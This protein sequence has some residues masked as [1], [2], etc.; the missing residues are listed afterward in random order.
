M[1]FFLFSVFPS[2]PQIEDAISWA[3]DASRL[4]SGHMAQARQ[5]EVSKETVV[6]SPTS[7]N[8]SSRLSKGDDSGAT[9]LQDNSPFTSLIRIHSYKE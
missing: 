6:N 1:C 8:W 2:L 5:S 3:N 9:L 7:S 4:P